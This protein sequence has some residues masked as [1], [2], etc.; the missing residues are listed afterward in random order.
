MRILIVAPNEHIA[1]SAMDDTGVTVVGAT[2]EVCEADIV[3]TEDGRLL[4]D[5]HGIVDEIRRV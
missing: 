5:R 4:K 1:L 3:I 2:Q